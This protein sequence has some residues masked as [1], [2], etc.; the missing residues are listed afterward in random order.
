ML[1]EQFSQS[2]QYSED[3][4]IVESNYKGGS[5]YITSQNK[6]EIIT[7]Q[8]NNN[9]EKFLLSQKKITPDGKIDKNQKSI[10]YK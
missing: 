3:G 4:N 5:K 8:Y 1:D 6:N 10:Y 7:T 2:V 9:K